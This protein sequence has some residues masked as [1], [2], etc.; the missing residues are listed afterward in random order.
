MRRL[1]VLKLIKFAET[2]AA[3]CSIEKTQICRVAHGLDV[4]D[5]ESF[6]DARIALTGFDEDLDEIL[7]QVAIDE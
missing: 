2:Y 4:T 1:D 6:A 3:L 7:N 5:E